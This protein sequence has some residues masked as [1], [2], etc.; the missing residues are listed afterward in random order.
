MADYHRRQTRPSTRREVLGPGESRANIDTSAQRS[1]RSSKVSEVSSP[2]SLPHNQSLVANGT[3]DVR[4][5]SPA[6]SSTHQ[7]HLS[8]AAPESQRAS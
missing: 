1:A 6:A 4:T 3:L 2:T 5:S 7:T 8:S